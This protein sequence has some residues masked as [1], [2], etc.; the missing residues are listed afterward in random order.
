MYTEVR[1]A[2]G[3]DERT[4]L[5][6]NDSPMSHNLVVG[7]KGEDIAVTF[8]QSL[9][10][11]LY[12]RN[13]RLARDEIDIITFDPHDKVLVFAEVKTRSRRSLDYAPDLNLTAAKKA[14]LR[15]SARAWVAE[16]DYEGGYRI[17]LVCV[18]GEKVVDHYKEIEWE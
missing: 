18:V 8:L 11:K 12:D 16:H 7:K 10:Y 17:D 5:W 15:R 9:G 13:V 3:L 4:P 2:K 1:R 14:K 6:K